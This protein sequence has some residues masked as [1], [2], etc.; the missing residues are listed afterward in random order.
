MTSLLR[1]LLR[2]LMGPMKAASESLK[3]ESLPAQ[4]ENGLT[5]CPRLLYTIAIIFCPPL[6]LN[7]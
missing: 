7:K 2:Q 1:P 6:V 4:E 5:L 3:N